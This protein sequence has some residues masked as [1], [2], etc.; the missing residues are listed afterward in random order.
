[1]N[2]LENKGRVVRGIGRSDSMCNDDLII[3]IILGK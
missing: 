2:P 3:R 1:M